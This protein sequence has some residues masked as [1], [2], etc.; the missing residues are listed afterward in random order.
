[1]I[2]KCTRLLCI[3]KAA[4]VQIFMKVSNWPRYANGRLKNNLHIL[5]S[6][7]QCHTQR[8]SGRMVCHLDQVILWYD[9]SNSCN[10]TC[11]QIY[12]SDNLFHQ[13]L[14]EYRY[15]IY[16]QYY[17]L[18]GSAQILNAFQSYKVL[19]HDDVCL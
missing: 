9:N 7:N 3:V 10:N 16:E 11:V 14:L 18:A 5:Y 13:C 15:E 19:G 4:F 2:S 17:L 6:V 8:R 1:M 12:L